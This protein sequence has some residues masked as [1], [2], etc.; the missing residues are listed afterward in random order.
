V[1]VHGGEIVVSGWLDKLLTAKKN[2]SG[3]SRLAYLRGEKKLKFP[4][5]AN[6]IKARL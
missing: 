5:N 6:K 1:R 2:D 4:M 3:Q